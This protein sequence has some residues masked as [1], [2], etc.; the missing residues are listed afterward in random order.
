ML[1]LHMHKHDNKV[2]AILRSSICIDHPGAG[3]DEQN[4]S[5]SRPE[6]FRNDRCKLIATLATCID[7]LSVLR[8]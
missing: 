8:E 3:T 7:R 2:G 5:H 1:L 6:D 4:G